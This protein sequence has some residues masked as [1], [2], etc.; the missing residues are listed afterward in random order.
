MFELKPLSRE[1]IPA[2]LEKAMRYRLLN[3]PGAA[4]SICHDVLRTDDQR[5]LRA[6]ENQCVRALL[7]QL[8]GDAHEPAPGTRRNVA[9]TEFGFNRPLHETPVVEIG[10]A[11]ALAKPLE[12]AAVE[13]VF[14]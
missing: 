10:H 6:G 13:V 9:N 4:E 14:H 12:L 8:T 1:A 11:H 3:E 5:Y 2:A 7:A